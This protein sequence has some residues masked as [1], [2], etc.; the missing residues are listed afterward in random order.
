MQL[1]FVRSSSYLFLV[2]L[3]LLQYLSYAIA[4]SRVALSCWQCDAPLHPNEIK[5][6]LG[7]EKAHIYEKYEQFSIRRALIVDP[8]TRWCPAPD[9]K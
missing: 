4:E 2:L 5:S 8:D 9:C 7:S 1:R 3:A 6:I